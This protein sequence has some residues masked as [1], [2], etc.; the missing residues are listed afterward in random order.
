MFQLCVDGACVTD[1]TPARGCDH[2]ECTDCSFG[3]DRNDVCANGHCIPSTDAGFRCQAD[4]ECGRNW[5]CG[6]SRATGETGRCQRAWYATHE[7][8]GGGVR[9]RDGYDLDCD[10][11][12]CGSDNFCLCRPASEGGDCSRDADCDGWNV[13]CVHGQCRQVADVCDDSAD[14]GDGFACADGR[15]VARRGR[16]C[17]AG[18]DC[19]NA[20]CCLDTGAPV[21]GDPDLSLEG[22]R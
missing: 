8:G 20:D 21:C 2:F 3:F 22:C 5:Y 15:C 7:L 9:C 12:V 17:E 11:W 13:G 19:G 4:F 18:P 6:R 16:T 10:R 1:A 14:C